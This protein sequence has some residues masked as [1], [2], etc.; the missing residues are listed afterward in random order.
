MRQLTAIITLNTDISKERLLE[1][2][3]EDILLYLTMDM[4]ENSK[5]IE[6]RISSESIPTQQEKS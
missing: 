5:L 3:K 4:H 1:D 6:I 2:L